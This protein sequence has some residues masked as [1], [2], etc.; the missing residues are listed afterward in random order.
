[1]YM[2]SEKLPDGTLKSYM[3]YSPAEIISE[4]ILSMKQDVKLLSQNIVSLGFDKLKDICDKR[5]LDVSEI[6]YFLPH[7]SSDFFRGKIAE[8]LEKNEMGIPQEK[9]FTNL[10]STG[11]VGAASIYLIID[12]LF[13]SGKLKKGNKLLMVIPESSRFS[14]VFGLLTVC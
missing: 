1:M 2:A 3:D 6:D 14:Y 13:N 5:G 4:S 12:E 10:S 8:T 7:L 11:N 9:W